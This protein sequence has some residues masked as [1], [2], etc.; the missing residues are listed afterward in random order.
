MI[1]FA[2]N[3]KTLLLMAGLMGLC[4]AVGAQF[5]QRGMLLALDHGHHSIAF[6]RHGAPVGTRRLGELH[7]VAR[8][9]DETR[10]GAI[11]VQ[12]WL[13]VKKGETARELW[14]R[15]VAPLGQKLLAD[16]IDYAKANNSLPAK[17]QDEEFATKAP[18]SLRARVPGLAPRLR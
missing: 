18:E 10:A 17:P 8:D 15:A 9:G 2:N 11:A 6:D 1:R 14:E 7:A 5:G 13:F 4:L 3:M 12:E 16:V